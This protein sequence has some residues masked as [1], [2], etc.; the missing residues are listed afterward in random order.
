MIVIPFLMRRAI[1]VPSKH[2]EM[3][4]PCTRVSDIVGT[5][6]R[7]AAVREPCLPA[8][9]PVTLLAFHSDHHSF[10]QCD[11]PNRQNPI[12]LRFSQLKRKAP[13]DAGL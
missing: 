8:D 2:D 9:L 7:L 4:T 13:N 3:R 10:L 5:T 11:L 12:R 6:V 1:I